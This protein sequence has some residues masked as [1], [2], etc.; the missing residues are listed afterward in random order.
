[1]PENQSQ[2]HTGGNANPEGAQRLSPQ[3][4]PSPQDF[5]RPSDTEAAHAPDEGR[6][7]RGRPDDSATAEVA[8]QNTGSLDGHPS[9]DKRDDYPVTSAV[10]GR[11]DDNMTPQAHGSPNPLG[12]DPDNEPD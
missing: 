2:A 6:S 7:F 8:D 5:D 1:M 3:P 12:A 4:D 11:G 9:R 10:Q